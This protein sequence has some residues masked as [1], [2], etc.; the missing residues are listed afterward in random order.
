[1]NKASI[2]FELKTSIYASPS[3]SRNGR[4]S[5]GILSQITHVAIQEMYGQPRTSGYGNDSLGNDA[6]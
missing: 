3:Y 4:N 5:N 6:W 1:M 2:H